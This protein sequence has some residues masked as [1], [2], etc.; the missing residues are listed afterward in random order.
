MLVHPVI[1]SWISNT[2]RDRAALLRDFG[3]LYTSENESARLLWVLHRKWPKARETWFDEISIA[4]NAFYDPE[5]KAALSS[6]LR[7]TKR[8]FG[9]GWSLS[10]GDQRDVARWL[11]TNSGKSFGGLML[12]AERIGGYHAEIVGPAH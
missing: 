3:P 7:L 9:G 11:V 1:A 5:L 4:T 12:V 6:F 10:A 2:E 8:R